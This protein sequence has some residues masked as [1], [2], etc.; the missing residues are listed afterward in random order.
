MSAA[1]L[2]RLALALAA[3]VLTIG[4]ARADE[5]IALRIEG[6]P[7]GQLEADLRDALA[8]SGEH[9]LEP[10][11]FRQ[12]LREAGLRQGLDRAFAS[13]ASRDKLVAVASHAA[14]AIGARIAVLGRVWRHAGARRVQLLVL[15]V[16]AGGRAA[17]LVF[18]LD[19]AGAASTR[20]DAVARL[21]HELEPV[22][23][24]LAPRPPP[25]RAGP[26]RAGAL[27]LDA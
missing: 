8:R 7:S 20:P 1:H 5:A 4:P 6:K 18:E 16:P 27:T 22:L 15:D 26:A 3:L 2:V 14:E 25:P 13:Q 21:R 19:R 23:D 9:V 10:E 24:R 17:E 11:D 12:A